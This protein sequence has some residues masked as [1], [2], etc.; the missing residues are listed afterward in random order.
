MMRS[1]RKNPIKRFKI[2]CDGIRVESQ[3]SGSTLAYIHSPSQADWE[4]IVVRVFIAV[5][6][7]HGQQQ[8]LS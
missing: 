7:H 5:T 8:Q 6:R 2:S 4:A 1:Y 3:L